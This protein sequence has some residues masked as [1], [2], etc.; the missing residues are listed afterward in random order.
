MKKAVL[1]FLLLSAYVSATDYF[2]DNQA[3]GSNTGTS[4]ADAWE[5]FSDIAW[6]SVGAGDTVYISGG[7]SSK[8]YNEKLN[9]GTSG[10][11]GNPVYVKAGAALGDPAHSGTVIIDVG[12]SGYGIESHD[13]WIV[14]DGNDGDG[15]RMIEVRN[16]GSYG[17]YLQGEAS[18]IKYVYL[19]HTG[20]KGLVLKGDSDSEIAYCRITDTWR[21]GIAS[22]CQD[23]PPLAYGDCGKIHHN[24]IVQIGE[25]GLNLGQGVDVYDN[26]IGNFIDGNSYSDGIQ[27]YG[28]YLRIWNNI[29]YASDCKSGGANALLFIELYGDSASREF[30]H[31]RVYNNFFYVSDCVYDQG[32]YFGITLKMHDHTQHDTAR[33]IVIANND[34]IDLR[35]TAIRMDSHDS[36]SKWRDL[37]IQNNLFE[38]CEGEI[39]LDSGDYDSSVI[40]GNSCIDGASFVSYSVGNADAGDFHLTESDT[41]AI[42]QGVDLSAYFTEDKDGNVRTGSWDIGAYEFQSGP[43]CGDGNCDSGEDCETCEADCG[44]CCGNGVCDYDETCDTCEADCGQCPPI[45]IPM[46]TAE[47]AAEINRWKQG[48]ITIAELMEAIAEWKQGC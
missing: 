5:S 46:T 1:V 31:I 17:I 29:F 42:D 15:N 36:S 10:V 16:T 11:S 43:S 9:I 18:V 37:L 23:D 28:G 41:C 33:D 7:S 24:E 32:R 26:V 12:D 35:Y 30:D 21:H 38:N 40:T 14:I 3:S 48:I 2:V 20:D 25:D 27:V 8:E 44:A 4:W 34:F 13:D 45:C 6:G 22:S 47:L 19:H 39:G